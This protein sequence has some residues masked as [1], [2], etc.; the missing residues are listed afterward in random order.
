MDDYSKPKHSQ[1]KPLRSSPMS[2]LKDA[3]L[4][5]L[6]IPVMLVMF[7]VMWVINLIP[8]LLAC[9]FVLWLAHKFFA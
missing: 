2:G 5:I 6:G 4:M 1:Y 7:I 3:C 8:L 9:L